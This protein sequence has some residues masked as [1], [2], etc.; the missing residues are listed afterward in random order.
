MEQSKCEKS[1]D[2]FRTVKD[3]REYRPSLLEDQVVFDF[4]LEHLKNCFIALK[5]IQNFTLKVK[6]P[7]FSIFCIL[8][9]FKLC[10]L[11][12]LKNSW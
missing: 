2:I 8:I 3:L 10:S 11:L 12:K 9:I 7:R 4:L 1:V 5:I 6:K